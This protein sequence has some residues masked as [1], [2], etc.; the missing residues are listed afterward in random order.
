MT[1]SAYACGGGAGRELGPRAHTASGVHAPLRPAPSRPA[2]VASGLNDSMLRVGLGSRT[3]R[4][5]RRS[6][7]EA[8][9]WW[10]ASPARGKAATL[11][12]L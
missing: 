3:Q 6:D 11:C 2:R 9:F 5:Q 8:T 1:E 4:V 7:M 10:N 12:W